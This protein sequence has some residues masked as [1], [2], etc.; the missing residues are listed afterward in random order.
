M[1]YAAEK[2]H[3]NRFMPMIKMKRIFSNKDQEYL[4]DFEDSGIDINTLFEEDDKK[5]EPDMKAVRKMNK[6]ME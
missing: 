3:V 2:S 1:K 6:R 4:K 5:N